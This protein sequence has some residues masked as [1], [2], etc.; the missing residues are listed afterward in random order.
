MTRQE[1]NETTFTKGM[2]VIVNNKKAYDII[3]VDFELGVIGIQNGNAL[4]L[5]W[6]DYQECEIVKGLM[7]SN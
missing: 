7:R 6:I 5:N 3:G 1:F 4:E 2:M